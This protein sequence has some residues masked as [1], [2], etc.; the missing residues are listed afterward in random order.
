MRRVLDQY[1]R[2][3][4]H[5]GLSAD[6]I[7]CYTI[8]IHAWLRWCHEQHITSPTTADIHRWLDATRITKPASRRSYLSWLAGYY[9][10]ATLEGLLEQDPTVRIARP[11]VPQG[12]PHP[13][14]EADLERALEASPSVRLTYWMTLGA[15]AGF[16][17]KEMAGVH[18]DDLL[19]AQEPQVIV[20]SNPKGRKQRSIPIHPRVLEAHEKYVTDRGYESGFLFPGGYGRKFILPGTVGTLITQHFE[21]LGIDAVPHALRHRF[22]TELYRKT[23]DIRLVQEMLG[24]ASPATTVIYTKLDL[25]DAANG[26]DLL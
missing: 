17:C 1:V 16:R 11:Y 4:E 24:H 22:G 13:I 14:S 9:R 18:T 19:L 8:T 15:Y 12:L 23:K 21:R 25:T 5:R 20:V 26:I 7:R 2:H 3:C 10:W 6:T